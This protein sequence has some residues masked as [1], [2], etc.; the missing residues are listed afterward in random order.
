MR[1]RR[2]FTAGGCYFFTVVTGQRKPI[3]AEKSAIALL[4]EAF[5]HVK[6]RYPFHVDAIVIPPDHL[7][8]VWTLP[9]EDSRIEVSES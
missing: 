3:F 1:Y 7:Y 8:V 2:A 6:D 5:R 9:T 4:R